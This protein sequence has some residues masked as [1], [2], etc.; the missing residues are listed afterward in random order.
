MGPHTKD[1]AV[2]TVLGA[3]L[4]VCSYTDARYGKVR[5]V[6]TAPAMV[7]GLTLNGIFG[8]WQGLLLGAE[9]LGLA[10]GLFLGLQL[11][12]GRVIGAGDAKMLMGVGALIGPVILA[13]AVV[14]GVL[15]GGIIAILV[16]LVTGRLKRELVGLVTSVAGRVTG[17]SEMD[18]G[19]SESVRLPYA[20]PLA[21]GTLLAV[22]LR[23]WVMTP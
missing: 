14:Y 18:Y 22:V 8:G 20:I 7:L 9:G 13:W 11:L 10:L 1:V 6:F 2:Y 16:T 5:N 4:V 12:L 15:V 21:M 19:K 17:A 23:G 3:L